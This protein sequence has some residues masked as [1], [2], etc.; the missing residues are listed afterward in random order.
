MICKLQNLSA[1][2]WSTTGIRSVLSLSPRNLKVLPLRMFAS[3]PVLS[4]FLRC[5]FLLYLYLP[6]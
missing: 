5:T 1:I 6:V 3:S 4:P 2:D